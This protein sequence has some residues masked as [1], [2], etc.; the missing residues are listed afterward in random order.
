MNQLETLKLFNEKAETLKGYERF[1][2]SIHERKVEFK[3]S[4]ETAGLGTI[5]VQGPDNESIAACVLTI[6]LFIQK[7]EAIFFQNMKK[8]Y[9]NLDTSQKNKNEFNQISDELDRY[10][11]S[12]SPL[13]MSDEEA[14]PEMILANDLNE[15]LAELSNVSLTSENR[16][17]NREILDLFIYG[18]LSHTDKTKRE[19]LKRI[20]SSSVGAAFAWYIFTGI[21]IQ[22]MIC[23]FAVAE[24]NQD[25]I[26]EMEG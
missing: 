20:L 1:M 22:I 6:R 23:I 13:V 5:T 4:P 19:K 21:L 14:N 2:E 12:G 26:N 25:V 15:R 17:T 16:L 10:L 7:K 18:D 24:I 9:D 8:V 3:Q 11:D